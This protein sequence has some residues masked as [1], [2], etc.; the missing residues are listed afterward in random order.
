MD[1]RARPTLALA[2]EL[3]ARP[4]VT[5]EDA[6]CQALIASRLAAL[7][8]R[9]ETI[10]SAGVTNLWARRGT[11]SPLV[12]FAG[13]TDV[14]PTGPREA[15]STDPFVPTERDGFLHGRGTADMKGSLAAFVTAI[16][17]FVA[18]H[19]DAPGSIAL[20]ITSDEEGPHNTDGTV[21]VV[22]RLR[23]RGETIDYCI[24]GEPSSVTRLGDMIKNGRRGTLTGVLTV[25]GV[26]G[27]VAYPHRARNP[28]HE[29]APAIA[30]LAGIEWDRG[31]AYFPP[32]TFQCS[33]LHAGTGAMNV[34]PGTLELAFNWRYSTE[35]T[36]E[37]LITRLR[38]VLDRRGLDYAVRFLPDGKPF[39]TP[40]GR[41]VEVV[42][43]AVRESTGVTPELSCTGGTSDGRF[44]A[45]IARELVELGPVGATIHQVDERVAIDDLERLSAIY[46]AVLGRL[47]VPG[48]AG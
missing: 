43:E 22:E 3:V 11:S 24:V 10:V 6:G 41:L 18:A 32:T 30:E 35:S 31:N 29:V 23:A 45:S 39:L 38:E 1:T 26:Q 42:S 34:I 27:H 40:R 8:F 5:P 17:A 15:W 47:L 33:N 14:V 2:R 19:P 7:G 9:A 36:R 28:I 46:R 20:L 44:I 21:K 25:R 48:R 13:H 4:S 16:E 37:S 12:C